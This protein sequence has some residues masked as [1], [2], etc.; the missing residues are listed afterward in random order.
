MS[1]KP[2]EV[3][4]YKKAGRGFLIVRNSATIAETDYEHIAKEIVAALNSQA[5]KPRKQ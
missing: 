3:A 1:M 5:A 2:Q 4:Q